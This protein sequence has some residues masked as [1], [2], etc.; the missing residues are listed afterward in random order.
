MKIIEET[1]NLIA[2]CINKQEYRPIENHE[3]ELKDSSTKND[4]TS[5]KESVCAFLNTEGGIVIIGINEKNKPKHYKLTGYNENNENNL[6]EITKVFTD[7]RGNP[8][9]VSAAIRYEIKDFMHKR[10]A[11]IYVTKLS[12]DIKYSLFNGIAYERKI[13]GDHPISKS[14]ILE[15]QEY[16]K[17]LELARELLP[18]KNTS[19]QNIDLDKLNEYIVYLNKE[20]RIE[21][22]KAN[23]ENSLS[24]LER[25]QFIQNEQVTIL[26]MLVCGKHP[27]D[28]LGGKCQV[29]CFVNSKIQVAQNKQILKD[30]ILPLLEKS[31]SFVFNNIQIGVSVGQGGSATYEYP[32]Q[33]LRETINNALAHRDYSI[34]KY[35]NINI[36]PNESV[37]IRNPG[38]FKD[39]LL[40][41]HEDKDIIIKRIIPNT[42]PKN[43]K[44]ADILKVFNK[45]EGKGIGMSVITNSALSNKIDLPYFRFY[46]DSDLSLTLPSGKLLDAKTEVLFSAFD[47]YLIKKN[48]GIELSYKQKIVI[49]YLYKS[50]L[51]N[52]KYRFTILLTPDNEHF[53]ILIDL[54]HKK[55]IYKHD[56]ST[57]YNPV[58]VLDKQL[59]KENFNSELIQLFKHDFVDLPDKYKQV[60]NLLY[61]HTFFSS[62]K[63]LS[64]SEIG[65][66]IWAH[67]GNSTTIAGFESFKR[68]IRNVVNKL[69]GKGMI[70]RLETKSLY[71]LNKNYKIPT[72]LFS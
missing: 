17:E 51:E 44:L 19:I 31:L 12:E 28:I 1:L 23:L 56:C 39:S 9:D 29:D 30:T 26:G 54:Q 2:N 15:H 52:K 69:E 60:L 62:Q 63:H 57:K 32:E 65:N 58:Y 11:I 43:P 72:T 35:V 53:N 42:K 68:S 46:D 55:I 49:A 20:V 45:W 25:K 59:F 22:I 7:D 64:A 21:T 4:F 66:K 71:Q 67:L 33:L 16:K 8:I 10:L 37:E 3:I 14:K 24:L 27:H 18:I 34:D 5:I 70:I 13:T 6:K 36:S 47:G 50:E 48:N 38:N 61:Q 41:E 40:I